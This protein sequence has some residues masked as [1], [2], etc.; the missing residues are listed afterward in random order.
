MKMNFSI[1]T[2]VLCFNVIPL[3]SCSTGPVK[4][5]RAGTSQA[6]FI[7]DKTACEEGLLAIGNNELSQQT[8][9]FEGCME[10]KG[11]TVMPAS[12]K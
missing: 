6:I 9:S 2:V 4:W 5:Y 1:L 7:K 11:Y 3:F 8:Y 12:S 10:A